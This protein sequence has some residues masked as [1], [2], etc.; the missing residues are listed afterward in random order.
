MSVGHGMAHSGRH[1][2]RAAAPAATAAS[3]QWQLPWARAAAPAS[4]GHSHKPHAPAP[5]WRSPRTAPPTAP[6][7]WGSPW[8]SPAQSPARQTRTGSCGAGGWGVGGGWMGEGRACRVRGVSGGGAARMGAQAN[9]APV[10][11][12]ELVRQ[13]ALEHVGERHVAAVVLLVVH[14]RV[15]ARRG[16]WEGCAGGRGGPWRRMHAQPHARACG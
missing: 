13:L 11:D 5:S 10:A 4:P 1:Q 6:G 16:R 15:P 7:C 12:G 9:S 2:L 14:Q 8:S 3:A